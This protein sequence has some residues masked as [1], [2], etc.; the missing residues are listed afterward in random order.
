MYIHHATTWT[1]R[2]NDAYMH[3]WTRPS[4]VNVMGRRLYA[5]KLLLNKYW[6]L[7]A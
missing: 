2:N 7:D 5:D 3:Q 4:L 6:I 1:Y